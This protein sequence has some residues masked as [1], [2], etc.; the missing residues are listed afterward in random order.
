[1]SRIGEL[2][3][4]FV[5]RPATSRRGLVIATDGTMESDGAVRVG[6]ALAHRDGVSADM[7]SVVE[8]IPAVAADGVAL[9]D[10]DY[11][12]GIACESRSDALITQR[13]R[14]HPGENNWPF[15]V[16]VG[17]RAETIVA[18]AHRA[19]ASMIV[20]GSGSHGVGARIRQRETA[21]R[22]IRTAD[23]PVLAVPRYG[24][25]VPRT[26]LA[27]I[28]F[29]LSSEHAARAALELLDGDGTLYLA[30]VSPRVPVP[31]GDPRSWK[32]IA[33]G[34]ALPE[35]EALADRL[36]APRGIRVE[37]ALLH[38]EPAHELLAFATEAQIDMIAA[39]MHGRSAIGRLVLGSVSTKLIRRAHCWIL[40][41]PP[42]SREGLVVR[43][44]P[45]ER[46]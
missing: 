20:L 34:S 31:Q 15:T 23:L 14:T 24:G 18:M 46:P 32:E 39:G 11:L 40:V 29:T 2:P 6:L 25:G 8:P 35:L 22:V 17:G 45:N 33:T 44:V 16:N 42:R 3:T 1:M 26:A 41:A 27:A 7:I 21:L 4:T 9:P 28:D 10:I 19:G 30:H 5:H 43:T 13:D 36:A 12:M 38:G 37:Y